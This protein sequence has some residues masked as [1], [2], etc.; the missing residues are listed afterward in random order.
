[1]RGGRGRERGVS[2]S[3]RRRN[4]NAAAA[5]A[6]MRQD[7]RRQVRTVDGGRQLHALRLQLD[8]LAGG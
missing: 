5:A 1:M 7:R 3:D 2:D 8:A 6:V 4:G